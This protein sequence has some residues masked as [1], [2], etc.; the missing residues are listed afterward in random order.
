MYI[1]LLKKYV[2]K[3]SYSYAFTSASPIINANRIPI[4]Q[5][6]LGVNKG[7]K[8]LRPFG[9]FFNFYF[10]GISYRSELKKFERRE[11]IISYRWVV[12]PD[13][14]ISELFHRAR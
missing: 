11:M 12:N 6:I 13:L 4:N 14:S 7:T 2:E 3:Q 9:P 8:A 1:N 10:Y 5:S